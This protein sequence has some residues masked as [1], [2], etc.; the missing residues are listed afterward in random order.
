LPLFT[1]LAP[2]SVGSQPT[3]AGP[4]TEIVFVDVGQGDCALVITPDNKTILIDG[5]GDAWSPGSVGEYSLLPYLKS[6]GITQIDLMVNSHPHADH[7]DG[8]LSVLTYLDVERLVYTDIWQDE[9]YG[10][11]LL[12]LAEQ[13]GVAIQACHTG[14]VLQV[15]DYLT[16]CFYYPPPG[17]AATEEITDNNGSL[18]LE[19]SCGEIDFL[20]DG[21]LDGELLAAIC[22]AADIEAE[23]IKVPH[24]GS[25]SGYAAD[26]AQLLSSEVA[27]ISVGRDNSYGHPTLKV[28]EYWQEHGEV[29]RTDND[30]SVSVF[31]NGAEY[32]ILT[33]N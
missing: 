13:Q 26:L 15:G 4:L 23:I 5:G 1:L 2:A 29:Y 24:H 33:Y 7:T 14:D 3:L 17:L 10:D 8:L 12:A 20:F 11:Q 9:E 25:S 28:V 22:G 6:R 31:T 19:L 30:G 16:L 18:V 21:D 32:Q 27:V